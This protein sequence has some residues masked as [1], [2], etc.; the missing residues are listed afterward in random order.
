MTASQERLAA[1]IQASRLDNHLREGR[2]ISRLYRHYYIVLRRIY[3]QRRSKR[4]SE[5]IIAE[6]TDDQGAQKKK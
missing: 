2:L 5:K 1:Q 6:L 3:G 4:K